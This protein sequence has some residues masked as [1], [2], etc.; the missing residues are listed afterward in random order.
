MNRLSSLVISGLLSVGL[1]SAE[2]WLMINDERAELIDR[3]HYWGELSAELLRVRV[4]AMLDHSAVLAQSLANSP[5]PRSLAVLARSTIRDDTPFGGLGIIEYVRPEQREAFE[6]RIANSIRVLQDRHLA[7]SPRR[8]ARC[9]I[10]S[11]VI[12]LTTA[13]PC[14]KA[15]TWAASAMPAA[16]WTWR[17]TAPNR[18]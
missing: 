6:S 10:R 11:P 12:C 1:L 13:T 17:A 14:R 8:P 3:Q 2:Y 5:Q 18:C 16:K 7:P 15:W 9:T 4:Q